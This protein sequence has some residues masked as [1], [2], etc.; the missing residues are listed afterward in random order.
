MQNILN[1][2]KTKNK[3]H[4]GLYKSVQSSPNIL[5]FILGDHFQP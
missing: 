4:M 5:M 3:L 1:E 2:G